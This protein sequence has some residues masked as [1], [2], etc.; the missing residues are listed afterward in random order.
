V[1]VSQTAQVGIQGE[2]TVEMHQAHRLLDG[3]HGE[4][5]S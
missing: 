2:P 1:N 3:A 5:R 4:T